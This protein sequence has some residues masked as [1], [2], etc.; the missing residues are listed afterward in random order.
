M[1]I[2]LAQTNPIVGAFDYNLEKAG[3]F[4]EEAKQKQCKLIIFPE[5]TLI[6]YPP[7]DLL[8]REDFIDN[9][10]ITLERLIQ[11]TKGIAVICG[12]VERNINHA[13]P[14]FNGAIFFEDGEIFLKTYKI[15]LPSYDVF[16]E[17]RYFAPGQK[18]RFVKW[19]NKKIGVTICE[20]IWNDKDLF[21]RQQYEFDP[22]I[23]L[24]QENIDI[25][26]NISASP[27]YVGK[28]SFRLKIFS[29][30]ANKYQFPVVYANQ[31]GGNDDIV[32]DGNSKIVLPDGSILAKGNSFA[33]D[34]V[35]AEMEKESGEKIS[36]PEEEAEV[37]KAIVL[38]TRDYAQKTGFKKA[39]VGL[40][41]GIDSSLVAYIGVQALGRE[42]VL[43][44][45]MPSPYTS[46]ES[47]EDAEALAKNLGIQYQVI[48]IT[49]VFQVYLKVLKPA[50][51]ELPWS[52]AEENIQARI[53]GNILMALSNKF[54]Y[55]VLSTG[56]KSEMAVGYCTLYGDLT[57]G[58]AVISDV[59][60]TMVYRLGRYINREAVVIPERVLTKPP[61]A[62]LRTNQR[63]EDDLPPY[64]I[65]D[66][67]LKEYIENQRSVNEIVAMGF[68]R[69]IVK[70]IVRKVD[71]S[72]YKRKQAPLGIK[73]TTKAFGYGR[74]YPIA[75]RYTD[76]L[77]KPTLEF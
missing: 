75:Q 43:G 76:C 42:N 20:D 29:H 40:S 13:K 46:K 64:H 3:R 70:E 39:I 12:Y 15:L 22:L 19:N 36:L 58:L 1:K 51:N 65:L 47:L 54:G 56:N 73:I 2:A 8:E 74:R 24:A 69:E 27:Y 11:R 4:I 52:A 38:G 23:Q 30:L 31:V 60:K 9:S 53:R 5:L 18:A 50:F 21:P 32:F 28:P 66:P 77:L 68:P 44:I 41:G 6:G 16:D 59:P 49:E 48:P 45:A 63:D 7:K 67:I 26:V 25:L 57:G 71:R 55:L 35:V 62:E 17:T 37:L 10:L 34:L 14:L 61:S 33:E 72:E